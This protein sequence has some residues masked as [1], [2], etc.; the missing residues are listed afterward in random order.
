MNDQP[1][2]HE[3]AIRDRVSSL[4]CVF[5]DYGDTQSVLLA[6]FG[7]VTDAR[8]RRAI[9]RIVRRHDRASVEAGKRACSLAAIAAEA[10]ARLTDSTEWGSSER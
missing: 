7:R 3:V 8:V 4:G 10:N 9:H 6:R 5:V 1:H 2:T